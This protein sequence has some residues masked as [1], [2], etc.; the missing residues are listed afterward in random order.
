ML[1]D[2]ASTEPVP[3]PEEAAARRIAALES[4]LRERN[5]PSVI[6]HPPSADEAAPGRDA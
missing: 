5:P 2:A 3:T 4:L 6:S 1:A